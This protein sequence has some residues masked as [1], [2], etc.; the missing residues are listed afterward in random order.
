MTARAQDWPHQPLAHPYEEI[1]FPRRFSPEELERIAKGRVPVKKSSKPS[2][3]T[4]AVD[5]WLIYQQGPELFFH[6]SASGECVF[7]LDLGAGLA[8]V[9]G[10]EGFTPEDRRAV[11]G[12]LI[13]RLLLDSK[14]PPPA[15]SAFASLDRERLEMA[16]RN[17][18][19]A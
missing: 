11:L 1:A 18:A 15:V 3:T 2:A 9:A 5:K 10:L 13:D 8:R 4:G 7:Q 6:R 16:W 12:Y 19:G 14:A 17:L